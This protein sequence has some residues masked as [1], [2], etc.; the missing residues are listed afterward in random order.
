MGVAKK[1]MENMLSMDM[2]VEEKL[3]RKSRRKIGVEV[4]EE[5]GQCGWTLLGKI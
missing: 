5:L 4:D 3:I 1:M 2:L